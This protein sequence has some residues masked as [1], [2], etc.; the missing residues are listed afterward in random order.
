MM[1]VRTIASIS[2]MIPLVT[3]MTMLI[4][5][6]SCHSRI[7]Q[8]WGV[9]VILVSMLFGPYVGLIAGGVGSSL[10]DIISGFSNYALVTL[11]KVWKVL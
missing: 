3:V 10:A 11:Q 8:L 9:A 5:Y 4:K 1:K 6:L 7:L 2:I